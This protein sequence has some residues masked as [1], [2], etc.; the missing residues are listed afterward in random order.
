MEEVNQLHTD[1]E[2]GSPSE[3]FSLFHTR[4]SVSALSAS[5]VLLLHPFEVSVVCN[6]VS[7]KCLFLLSDVHKREE[8]CLVLGACRPL[9]CVVLGDLW[10]YGWVGAWRGDSV[11]LEEGRRA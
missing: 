2:G 1:T 8:L 9:G 5:S 4:C 7:Y 11:V 6:A 10:V 3:E